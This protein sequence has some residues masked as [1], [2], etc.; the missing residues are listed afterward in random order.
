MNPILLDLGV[1]TIRWYTIFILLGVIIGGAIIIKESKKWKIDEQF[2]LNLFF[3]TII[4]SLIG[5]RLYYVAFNWNLY[6]NDLISIL[7]VWEGGLAIHGGILFGLITVIIYCKKYKISS[8]QIIDII[9]PGLII[10][11]AI[12]R[13]GNFFNSEAHGMV[14]TYENLKSFFIPDFIING[15]NINGV[16]YH[17][18][19]LYESILCIIG[20]IMI[21]IIRRSRYIKIGQI[22]GIYFMWYGL[23]RFFIEM[24][25]TDSLMLGTFKVAQ[26]VSIIMFIVGL[27][28]LITRKRES[29]FEDRYNDSKNKIEVK[30]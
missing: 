11:Q 29:R 22:T 9:V 20:F 24:M 19:F 26:I 27:I 4:F 13:W 30:F 18:T 23:I 16:Y 7:K 14:T 28:L 5:A 2:I 17:P 15:M 1:I 12:G 8:L 6:S 10:G 3:Y 21:L 25:R